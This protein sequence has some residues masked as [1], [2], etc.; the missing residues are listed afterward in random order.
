MS[1]SL[2]DGEEKRLPV[3]PL[4]KLEMAVIC[5]VVFSEAFSITMIFPFLS[6]MIRGFGVAHS[7][8][9]IALYS[10][11]LAG[12][13]NMAQFLASFWWGRASDATS[14][15]TTLLCGLAANAGTI[16]LFGCSRSFAWAIIARICNGLANGNVAIAKSYIQPIS[17]QTNSSRCYA[18]LGLSW[19]VGLVVGP[20]IG[21]LLANITDSIPALGGTGSPFEYFPYLLPCLVSA[22]INVTGFVI[23]SRFLLDRQ[24]LF[25]RSAANEARLAA[26]ARALG[27]AH[28]GH[29]HSHSRSRSRSCSRSRSHSRSHSY[30]DSSLC[31]E[32]EDDAEE[33]MEEMEEAL[34]EVLLEEV[35]LGD[36][37][38]VGLEERESSWVVLK[39][40]CGHRN[41]VL[42]VAAY[43]SLSFS[44]IVWDEAFAIWATYDPV[45]SN[46]AG[47][48]FSQIEVAYVFMAAGVTLV[49]VQGGIMAPIS[50]MFGIKFVTWFTTLFVAP[51]ILIFPILGGLRESHPGAFWSLLMT[52]AML[53]A[54]FISCAFTGISNMTN[55][56]VGPS[57]LGSANGMAQ[58][59]ASLSRA[60]GPFLGGLML[61]WSLK[62]NT[63]PFNHHF[64][65]F[66]SFVTYVISG[67]TVLFIGSE[68]NTRVGAPKF[69]GR[70]LVKTVLRWFGKGRG[71]DLLD[72]SR[73][74]DRATPS[75]ASM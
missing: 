21:G 61:S 68:I 2:E 54:G 36:E 13:F 51:I 74:T 42:T 57:L 27:I 38:E 49:I 17:D 67:V 39:Q 22:V 66:V 26:L 69:Q 44:T 28:N 14:R 23:G 18:L 63:W 70:G 29:S 19:G 65:F 75:E 16:L 1:S 10:G 4:P 12:S 73:S 31:I 71:Y 15:R 72:R 30:S 45:I 46:G 43:V 33:M 56:S 60:F 55:N 35:L 6:R 11:F 58:S 7:E 32:T 8:D 48:R 64:I 52:C 41:L 53:R 40:L 9:E 37:S 50:R 5:C 24:A 62:G 59:A 3:T 20:A 25:A 34:E 47:Y